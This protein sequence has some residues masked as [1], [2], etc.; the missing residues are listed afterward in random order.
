MTDPTPAELVNAAAVSATNA[1]TSAANATTAATALQ[2]AL[3]RAPTIVELET[4]EGAALYLDPLRVAA[5]LSVVDAQTPAAFVMV[6]GSSYAVKGEARQ[7]AAHVFA[8]A[9]AGSD[10]VLAWSSLGQPVR[11]ERGPNLG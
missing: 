1:A 5:V 8:S 2:Q 11:K 9:W 3:D 4:V 6:G 7:V 10:H